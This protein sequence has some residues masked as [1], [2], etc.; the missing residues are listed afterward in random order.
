MDAGSPSSCQRAI[1]GA[2]RV[3]EGS[4]GGG[5]VLRTLELEARVTGNFSG[6]QDARCGR[7]AWQGRPH[8]PAGQDVASLAVSTTL[9]IRRNTTICLIH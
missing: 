3:S 1:E 6:S 2:C 9:P 5:D 7:W 8:A 4:V